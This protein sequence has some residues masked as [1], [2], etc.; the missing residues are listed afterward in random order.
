[1]KYGV[2]G[3]GPSG[4]TM[5]L[6]LKGSCQVLEKDTHPGGHASSFQ[7][8]GFTFDYGPHI[9]FSKNKQ[10]LDFM[11]ASLGNN[12]HRC[13]RNNKIFYKGKLIKYPFENDLH[14]LPLEDNFDCLY[15]YLFNLYKKKYPKPKNMREW[16]L[17]HF[18]KGICE[19]YLF[20]YNEKVW[21]IPVEKLSM[22]WAGRIPNPP[23]ED[24]I[25]SSIGF[26]TEGYLH[27]LYYHYPLRGGYQAISDAWAAKV[28]P[29][30]GFSVK[31]IQKTKKGSY[32]VTDGKET[33]EYEQIISTIPIHE[34]IHM[35]D[36][37]IPLSVQQA[38]KRLI[39]NPMY[40][41]SLGIR[42]KDINQYTAM[43]FPQPDFLVNRISFPKT[44]SPHNAPEGHYS[45]QAEITCRMNSPQ[46]KQKDEDILNYVK[47]GLV[48]SGIIQDT[49]DIAYQNIR[50]SRYSYVVYDREYEKNTNIIRNWFP[51]Q[52]IHLV[53]R[54]SYFEYVNIDGVIERSLEIA[55]KLN[56]FPVRVVGDRVIK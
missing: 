3:G 20:P 18:G 51:K 15:S 54:F 30:Y 16:F 55:S 23:P 8:E 31:K 25:K 33:I 24:I 40:V 14:S 6:F 42:G 39:V 53:G 35:L 21:N 5:A 17:Y 46:W 1:M 27:Q 22:Q 38:V 4:L 13:K 47:K 19:K 41:I 11:I 49:H 56:G 2:L 32:L 50:R 9:M 34:L 48:A 52:G 37:S 36:L 12:V 10:A 7:E 43:Y 28:K 45:I 44:F 26:D 29:R